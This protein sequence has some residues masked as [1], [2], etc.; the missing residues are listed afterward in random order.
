MNKSCGRVSRSAMLCLR[1]I[2][3]KPL[4]EIAR[5]EKVGSKNVLGVDIFQFLGKQPTRAR[6]LL[7]LWGTRRNLPV[8]LSS[9][10]LDPEGA[11]IFE[12]GVNNHL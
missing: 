5:K 9:L 10:L 4:Y 1:F 2:G 11:G 6:V 7:G 12:R 8:L 3:V